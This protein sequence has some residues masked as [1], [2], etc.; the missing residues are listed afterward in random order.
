[1]KY[2]EPAM[3]AA[4]QETARARELSPAEQRLDDQAQDAQAWAAGPSLTA[5]F[6]DGIEVTTR[7]DQVERVTGPDGAAAN[8]AELR[9]LIAS[10]RDN[11]RM[12]IY[13]LRLPLVAENPRQEALAARSG[14]PRE[15]ADGLVQVIGEISLSEALD[16]IDRYV[17]EWN[18]VSGIG[19]E[20]FDV[21]TEL[22]AQFNESFQGMCTICGGNRP[23]DGACENATCL[24]HRITKLLTGKEA[25]HETQIH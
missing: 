11:A 16:A 18:D 5:L 19:Q 8:I 24:S 13:A 9:D 7:G 15:F 10:A 6:P 12:E 20:W 1:M 4:L 2:V 25:K 14:T 3:I 17:T 22:S 21:L 23:T